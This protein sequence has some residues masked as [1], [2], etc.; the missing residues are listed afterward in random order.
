MH[1]VSILKVIL[2]S[3]GI[4]HVEVS[5]EKDFHVSKHADECEDGECLANLMKV[6]S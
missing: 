4:I 2:H 5:N 6:C 3:R 1:E